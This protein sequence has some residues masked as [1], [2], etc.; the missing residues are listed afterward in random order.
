MVLY[1]QMTNHDIEVEGD[2]PAQLL[3]ETVVTIA[4]I[5]TL[6]F[7]ASLHQRKL[8]RDWK[9]AHVFSSFKKGSH[10]L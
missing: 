4:P 7:K 6:I 10:Q 8:P 9:T 5:L 3:K 1:L 2:S